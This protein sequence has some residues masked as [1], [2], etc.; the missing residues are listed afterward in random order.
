MIVFGGADREQQHY[1]DSI[2]YMSTPNSTVFG[3]IKTDG[4]I[5]TERCGHFTVAYGKYIF[6]FGGIDFSEECVFND[7]YLL[8]TGFKFY[9]TFNISLDISVY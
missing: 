9:L 6:L 3:N 2:A 1:H 8:D 5:P 7:L 4:D